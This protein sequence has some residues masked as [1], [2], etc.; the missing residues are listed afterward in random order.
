M[1]QQMFSV[2]PFSTLATVVLNPERLSRFNTSY[3]CGTRD[4]VGLTVL[5]LF[6]ANMLK[7]FQRNMAYLFPVH[8]V[9][10]SH[11]KE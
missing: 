6:G 3:T 8:V 11:R 9:R 4:G 7:V 5:V 1:S 2:G 10:V